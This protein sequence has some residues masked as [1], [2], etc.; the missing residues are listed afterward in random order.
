MMFSR[1]CRSPA[2]H[3]GASGALDPVFRGLASAWVRFSGRISR[4][5][6][7]FVVGLDCGVRPLEGERHPGIPGLATSARPGHPTFLGRPDGKR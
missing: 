6:E 5:V 2:R 7:G 4:V 1:V 3:G